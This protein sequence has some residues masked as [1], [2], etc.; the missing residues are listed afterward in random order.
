MLRAAH[1][2]T[3]KTYEKILHLNYHIISGTTFARLSITGQESAYADGQLCRSESRHSKPPAGSL[4]RV[5]SAARRV[6]PTCNLRPGSASRRVSAT[7]TTLTISARCHLRLR[8]RSLANTVAISL[9]KELQHVTSDS[10]SLRTCDRSALRN[11][12]GFAEHIF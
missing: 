11:V 1:E 2:K 6:P 3:G 4:A 12:N 10:L 8:S 5:A 7:S 9:P